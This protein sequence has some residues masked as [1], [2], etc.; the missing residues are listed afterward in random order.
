[1]GS[2]SS[3]GVNLN[4]LI[5]A[6]SVLAGV[7]LSQAFMIFCAFRRFRPLVPTKAATVDGA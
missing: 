3:C 4:A 7:A 1:M 6:L 5:P 2:S